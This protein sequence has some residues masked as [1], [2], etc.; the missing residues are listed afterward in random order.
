MPRVCF[1]V[2]GDFSL[3][4]LGNR[5][6]DILDLSREF[7]QLGNRLCESDVFGK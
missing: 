2:N 6:K 1:L 3:G 4:G 5:K 7:L